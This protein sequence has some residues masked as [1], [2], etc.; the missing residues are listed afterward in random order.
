LT[1]VAEDAVIVLSNGGNLVVVCG[2]KAQEKGYKA[3]EY[4]KKFGKGGGTADL[5]Q[6]IV[7]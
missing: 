2:R 7:K 4:I 1:L 5:A 6:G 3:H